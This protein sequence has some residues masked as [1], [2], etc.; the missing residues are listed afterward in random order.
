MK[1]VLITG[2]NRDLGLE[3]VRQYAQQGWCAFATCRSPNNANELHGIAK[4]HNH[5]SIHQLDVTKQNETD[6][7]AKELNT[8]EKYF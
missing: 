1:S 4:K 7:L 3:W 8:Y 6:V 5:V 2:C